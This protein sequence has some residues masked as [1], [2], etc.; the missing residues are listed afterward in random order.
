MKAKHRYLGAIAATLMLVIGST[1]AFASSSM[2]TLEDA[3][4]VS[5]AEIKGPGQGAEVSYSGP[6]TKMG[7]VER[8]SVTTGF[9]IFDSGHGVDLRSSPLFPSEL[10]DQFELDMRMSVMGS[11]GASAGV[12]LTPGP[13]SICVSNK[14]IAT[15]GSLDAAYAGEILGVALCGPGLARGSVEVIGVLPDGADGLSIQLADSEEPVP[16]DVA[17]N[18]YTATVHGKPVSIS[19]TMPDYFGP[20]GSPGD[21]ADRV[22]HTA[23][24][25]VPVAY[26]FDDCDPNAAA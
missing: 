24:L 16:V 25:P 7:I 12:T 3:M 10:I 22:T 4:K 9:G 14:R 2:P 20:D 11:D 17:E 18:A 15:C 26:S 6:S 5:Q 23:A 8:V 19:W 1:A 13:D 21:D